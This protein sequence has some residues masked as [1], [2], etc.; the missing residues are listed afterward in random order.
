VSVTAGGGD[1]AD[2]PHPPNAP[3]AAAEDSEARH[4]GATVAD[5]EDW[6]ITPAVLPP[7]PMVL[8][9]ASWEQARSQRSAHPREEEVSPPSVLTAEELAALLRVNRKTVYE[10][11]ARGEIPGARRIGAT[12]RIHRSRVLEWLASSQGRVPR[13]RSDR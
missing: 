11:L 9:R 6:A 4:H 12:Y 7:E 10:A 13:S 8:L 3:S 5:E 1:P 2:N